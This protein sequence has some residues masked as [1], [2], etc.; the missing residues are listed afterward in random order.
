MD[1]RSNA[2]YRMHWDYYPDD[3]PRGPWK[4]ENLSAGR[5]YRAGRFEIVE[6]TPT[7]LRLRGGLSPVTGLRP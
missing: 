5:P 7:R 4:A 1:L 2:R 3:D 6:Q